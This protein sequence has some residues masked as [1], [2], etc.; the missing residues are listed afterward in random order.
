MEVNASPSLTTSTDNDRVNKTSL[1][2]DIYNVVVPPSNGSM[3]NNNGNEEITGNIAV[4]VSDA[5]KYPCV[6]CGK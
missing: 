3:S 2:R 6:P 1:L 4:G 5:V